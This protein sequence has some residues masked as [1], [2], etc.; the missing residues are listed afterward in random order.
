MR[1]FNPTNQRGEELRVLEVAYH[2]NC[3]EIILLQESAVGVPEHIIHELTASR[4]LATKED[5]IVGV[6]CSVL[7][8]ARLILSNLRSSPI[9]GHENT[10][11]EALEC[12]LRA[13]GPS[14]TTVLAKLEMYDFS[15]FHPYSML[16]VVKCLISI[17]PTNHERIFA[18]D[19]WFLEQSKKNPCINLV[20]CLGLALHNDLNVLP[21]HCVSILKSVAARKAT[22]G[23]IGDPISVIYCLNLVTRHDFDGIWTWVNGYKGRAY[24]SAFR[25][26]GHFVEL[27]DPLFTSGEVTMIHYSEVSVKIEISTQNSQS[28]SGDSAD[29]NQK[30]GIEG[31]QVEDLDGEGK[32]NTVITIVMAHEISSEGEIINPKRKCGYW[33]RYCK[34]VMSDDDFERPSE[35]VREDPVQDSPNDHR[36]EWSSKAINVCLKQL[37]DSTTGWP[38]QRF[39]QGAGAYDLLT[40]TF[41]DHRVVNTSSEFDDFSLRLWDLATQQIVKSGRFT[42]P[43]KHHDLDLW[44]LT[45]A[46]DLLSDDSHGPVSRTTGDLSKLCGIRRRAAW[47][48]LTNYFQIRTVDWVAVPV[49]LAHVNAIKDVY[50]AAE[51]FADRIQTAMKTLQ[52]RVESH[53]VSKIQLKSIERYVSI[54]SSN[55]VDCSW[56]KCNQEFSNV[57]QGIYRNARI[58]RE[59]VEKWN[60]SDA[61]DLLSRLETLIRSK[62]AV[63][64]C[65]LEL[66]HEESTKVLQPVI[67][68]ANTTSPLLK[69]HF[70]KLAGGVPTPL[71]N[72][73]DAFKKTCKKV[74]S[75]T[76]N[77]TVSE[78][79][80]SLH[81]P[82]GNFTEGKREQEQRL[83]RTLGCSEEVVEA[84][85]EGALP[86]RFMLHDLECFR[87]LATNP[88]D[89]LKL[90]SNF[91]NG[92]TI[93]LWNNSDS[94]L[95]VDSI[96]KVQEVRAAS[97]GC[98]HRVLQIMKTVLLCSNLVRFTRENP[99]AQ[100]AGLSSVLSNSRDLQHA[101]FQTF[102]DCCNYVNPF[103][104]ASAK[105][106]ENYQ[107]QQQKIARGEEPGVI[108]RTPINCNS[109]WDG[110]PGFW[111]SLKSSFGD[112]GYENIIAVQEMLLK[113]TEDQKVQQL[114]KMI[115]E[116]N[117]T[118]DKL[119]EVCRDI[120]GL[121]EN[122]DAALVVIHLPA[123]GQPSLQCIFSTISWT[124]AE[125]Q[126][127]VYRA[128]LQRD[129][130]DHLRTFVSQAREVLRAYNAAC[131]VF[132]EG[133]LEFRSRKLTFK[134]NDAS[135][136]TTILQG[137]LGQWV[138]GETT[139]VF[140]EACKN[141][142]ELACVA[143]AELVRMAELMRGVSS[144]GSLTVDESKKYCKPWR[145]G[146]R[147][148]IKKD[149]VK[150]IDERVEHTDE[151]PPSKI[152]PTPLSAIPPSVAKFYKPSEAK[153]PKHSK[154]SVTL[155][156]A[157]EADGVFIQSLYTYQKSP[158]GIPGEGSKM[159]SHNT[160]QDSK[161][162]EN[163]KSKP[164]G[165]DSDN[166]DSYVMTPVNGGWAVYR[167]RS[168]D[169]ERLMKSVA[170][171]GG[172]LQ[173]WE[174][175][176]WTLG[177]T[178]LSAVRATPDDGNSAITIWSQPSNY[179]D[180]DKHISIVGIQSIDGLLTH[181]D[182]NSLYIKA[183]ERYTLW[184]SFGFEKG[185]RIISVNNE[186]G[187]ASELNNSLEK[188]AK[189]GTR[190]NVTLVPAWIWS[191][192]ASDLEKSQ[193]SRLV[194]K[195][196]SN[197]VPS[198]ALSPA[199]GSQWR[200]KVGGNVSGMRI[201]L[202]TPN[203]NISLRKVD[204]GENSPVSWWLL[205]CG[206]LRHNG[207]DYD[208]TRPFKAGDIITV[209]HDPINKRITFLL[210]N[211]TIRASFEDV[212]T[213]ENL[214]PVVYLLHETASAEISLGAPVTNVMKWDKEHK[215]DLIE[216]SPEGF[217]ASIKQ[218]DSARGA[219]I[220]DQIFRGPGPH[221]FE[222]LVT[223]SG[224][225]EC[226][227]GVAPPGVYLDMC[228][229]KGTDL[230]G[231]TIRPDGGIFSLENKIIHTIQKPKTTGMLVAG[232]R[233]TFVMDLGAGSIEISRGGERL[234]HTCEIK[235]LPTIEGPLVPYCVFMGKC[236]YKCTLV[237]VTPQTYIS[238]VGE[239]SV[240]VKGSS[241]SVDGVY[242][243]SLPTYIRE[244]GLFTIQSWNGR[245]CVAD[246]ADVPVAWSDEVPPLPLGSHP[247]Q[248]SVVSNF[249]STPSTL[250]II[251]PYK[252][253]SRDSQL[254]Q[255][256]YLDN[257]SVSPYPH[258]TTYSSSVLHLAYCS[259]GCWIVT[260]KGNNK[261][262]V[263][264]AAMEEVLL[265][266]HCMTWAFGDG[267]KFYIDDRI[268]I[269]STNDEVVR[270]D[271]ITSTPWISSECDSKW[272]T[273]IDYEVTLPTNGLSLYPECNLGTAV[274]TTSDQC[275]DS[276]TYQELS[277]WHI[278][279]N[280]THRRCTAPELRLALSE[281]A[282]GSPCGVE[283][284]MN[285]K[286]VQ[287]AVE[288]VRKSAEGQLHRIGSFLKQLR[289]R[290]IQ[291]GNT[292][293]GY[294]SSIS[295]QNFNLNEA[296]FGQ[297]QS[298]TIE[299][300]LIDASRL[301]SADRRIF[302]LSLFNENVQHFHIL[303]CSQQ[304][305]PEDIRAFIV[306]YK[307]LTV[308]RLVLLNLQVLP[309][310]IQNEVRK[311]AEE[312]HL[313]KQLIAIIT[314][315]IG[316]D[317]SISYVDAQSCDVR[318]RKYAHERVA[319]LKKFESI[320]YFD[321]PAGTGKSYTIE[322]LTRNRTVTKLDLDSTKITM[323]S[324]CSKLM[325]PL[326]GKQGLLVINVG[327]DTDPAFVN[328]C[329]DGLALFGKLTSASG[330]TV[331][332]PKTGW[333]LIVEF[334]QIW[335]RPDGT[336]DITLLACRGLAELGTLAP[337]DIEAIPGALAG[338]EFLHNTLDFLPK[339]DTDTSIRMLALGLRD[340]PEES[341]HDVG[342]QQTSQQEQQEPVPEDPVA[343]EE[344]RQEIILFRKKLQTASARII[345]R[346][347]KFLSNGHAIFAAAKNA[348]LSSPCIRET[349][350]LVALS[351]VHEMRHFVN[352]S[353]ENHFHLHPSYIASMTQ[354]SGD[355]PPDIL[356]AVKN[357]DEER[358]TSQN[359]NAAHG[360]RTGS[361]TTEA[362][363]LHNKPLAKHVMLLAEELGLK[364]GACA[365]RLS[366]KNYVLIPDF[367]Q[368]LLQVASHVRLCDPAVLQGPSGTGK[369]CA[370]DIITEL[371]QLPL[372]GRAKGGCRD[373]AFELEKFLRTDRTL[374]KQ[375]PNN[376]S[377]QVGDRMKMLWFITCSKSY[378]QCID[379]FD[380][381]VE[382]KCFSGLHFI[383][384]A[385]KYRFGPM[386]CDT[387]TNKSLRLYIETDANFRNA[388]DLVIRTDDIDNL[389]P[390]CDASLKI[391]RDALYHVIYGFS[392]QDGGLFTEQQRWFFSGILKS[393]EM[394]E[395]VGSSHDVVIQI[396]NKNPR[397]E[398]KLEWARDA[399]RRAGANGAAVCQLVRE[400]MRSEIRAS[401]LLK[402]S[403][404]LLR[405]LAG[406]DD[407]TGPSGEDLART[408]KLYQQMP[409]E[410][411][412]ITILM[413]YGMTPDLL[414]DLCRPTLERAL[415][416]PAMQFLVMIDEMNA[417][418]ML[419][420]VKRIVIDKQWDTWGDAHPET[421]GKLPENVAFVGAVNPAKKDQYLEGVGN[422]DI[423]INEDLDF[424]VTPMPSSLMEHIV[425]W[426]QL[427]EGQRELFI[428]RLISSNRNLFASNVNSDQINLLGT[429]LLHA[430][431]FVQSVYI[432]KRATVS[433]RDI[434]RAMKVFDFFFGRRYDYINFKGEL[435]NDAW[436]CAL[437]SMLL[438]IA[439]S[440]Y[441]R[442]STEN[443]EALSVRLTSV[444]TSATSIRSL[445]EGVTFA[446]VARNAVSHFCS[447]QHLT[448]PDAVYAHQA[449]LENLFVQMVCFEN[450]LAVILHGPPGTSKTLSNNIIRDN[451][452]G[453]G[454]FWNTLCYISE[455]CFFFFVFL[456]NF[457]SRDDKK[458]YSLLTTPVRLVDAK[459]HST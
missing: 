173:P 417:T 433:Q 2:N 74:A 1:L 232:D 45:T 356:E 39:N 216:I 446:K 300:N 402:P 337:Y 266:H 142:P 452:T 33:L 184:E 238:P 178:C 127:L 29:A 38:A 424:D 351:L 421:E 258:S 280:T 298:K 348:V 194:S 414:F 152:K 212:S 285:W 415:L 330:L 37:E 426:K 296:K 199:A 315:G 63:E 373:I 420:L 100:D 119:I 40:H 117:G 385:T 297:M 88:P 62:E 422:I 49:Q 129:L 120:S 96:A 230:F 333:K 80:A 32:P 146:R 118:T 15:D 375:F 449:L 163:P 381:L 429:V 177:D 354:F 338:L 339:N 392:K 34:L 107:K 67:D 13:L 153:L 260:E 267:E 301:P 317:E 361:S 220:G 97:A 407:I 286:S 311:A 231:L 367:L 69:A 269:V 213:T 450:R 195:V 200:I 134:H 451:M 209:C 289:Q 54:L 364:I 191:V 279:E 87:V 122:I 263:V 379:C 210:N 290:N 268:S 172:H 138:G 86:L 207:T 139:S 48:L 253:G 340:N 447:P 214:R 125:Y 227:F 310:D 272:N 229:N 104:A 130:S 331:S 237:D 182:N 329:L 352:P 99:E 111:E 198:L 176:D 412:T 81:P 98:T 418:N 306:F 393:S 265:P 147:R 233:I 440:Y 254:K 326:R 397:L 31:H 187:S 350:K 312:E 430:H 390:K 411:A 47:T 109:S 245:W 59:L 77:T 105:H 236:Q 132:S 403:P 192:V 221:S 92:E 425:P 293:L 144:I 271:P 106:V 204:S 282:K 389:D 160:K 174:M 19:G 370:V 73:A 43:M 386:V 154:S 304:T 295:I 322:K 185:M 270:I 427:A 252:I 278:V 8:T 323:E 197:S 70:L 380:I 145:Q 391:L 175:G 18:A 416:C 336:S 5:F 150:S 347:L 327:H 275:L 30:I 78:A 50:P 243:Q 453:R 314:E 155:E 208:V 12:A 206:L 103:V 4:V 27:L 261:N 121:H 235:N 288:S 60:V 217:T 303:D 56:Q 149:S 343:T 405:A 438:G 9:P 408:I 362:P 64:L 164:T 90:H 423:S 239:P 91:F 17:G 168:Y 165:V 357:W 186:K 141:Y 459:I 244:D 371:M 123:T 441:Y 114:E 291:E 458:E 166:G 53:R 11:K 112:T 400:H 454:E 202:C 378:Q 431:R 259:E 131:R 42:L 377:D 156:G 384:K 436:V 250:R 93:L 222:F 190:F 241:S 25:I 167:N 251:T 72:F 332:T 404:E 410:P 113:T 228:R 321:Q 10:F 307:L 171:H 24:N 201:G 335:R 394:E 44:V 455:V 218:D 409:S 349:R 226:Y 292:S 334:Q 262:N 95:L 255:L 51:Q 435:T 256:L 170:T 23:S 346:S 85:L 383:C 101:S 188:A 382:R 376:I 264:L 353:D 135:R 398:A 406:G 82:N 215:S 157:G 281:A 448:L 3:R 57:N 71:I 283:L 443:R 366:E 324:V 180:R 52:Q 108:L 287:E 302:G 83:L 133:H 345:T 55:G 234:V 249:K 359:R 456:T 240:V 437:S 444:V 363:D 20:T 274:R 396:L 432:N 372:Q 148:T 46:A 126:D 66:C 28:G 84:L 159:E 428:T 401:P 328:R 14:T 369:S 143:P 205:R 16:T 162:T 61:D 136:I 344:L 248:W 225:A 76:V 102:L 7:F 457:G 35:F 442:L 6:E 320:T 434:H 246:A 342:Q 313:H 308:G 140:Y 26:H 319:K 276:M 89:D 399:V 224:V 445:P 183:V 41:P 387:K 124:D 36:D 75:L 22:D 151:S 211:E 419:G 219:V 325:A 374:K 273:L 305:P 68:L 247:L 196:E 115:R 79:V 388:I 242:E 395:L 58:L 189:S 94:V 116:Q 316:T 360:D 21:A 169:S 299:G 128:T 368:K 181:V 257:E 309:P 341:L 318:W 65:D 179:S 223:G 355:T 413:R 193:S 277:G 161:S 294:E 203:I 439:V 158:S 365:H 284:T 358:Q 110:G 137:L